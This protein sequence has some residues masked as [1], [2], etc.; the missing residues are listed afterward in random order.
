MVQ[1]LGLLALTAGAPQFNPW[2]G[3]SVPDGETKISQAV[4]HGQ[5]QDNSKSFVGVKKDV[6]L[7]WEMLVKA[8][9]QSFQKVTNTQVSFSN[10]Q[11]S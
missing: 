8:V 9:I 11:F 1:W 2:L 6:A 10:G 5:K 7:H 4:Q 3:C